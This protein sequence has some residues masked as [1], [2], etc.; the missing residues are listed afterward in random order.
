MQDTKRL[1]DAIQKENGR[2]SGGWLFTVRASK[3]NSQL[4]TSAGREG[5]QRYRP[6]EESMLSR[7]ASLLARVHKTS[8]FVI[9]ARVCPQALIFGKGR[10]PLGE[11]AFRDPPITDEANAAK[12]DGLRGTQRHA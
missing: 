12:G 11:G 8:D 4:S 2:G 10:L 1:F 3:F 9:T 7:P 6:Q 5:I